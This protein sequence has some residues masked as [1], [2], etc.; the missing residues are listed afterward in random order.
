VP[1]PW[2]HTRT[3]GR[4][5]GAWGRDMTRRGAVD[6]ESSGGEGV[7]AGKKVKR[8]RRVPLPGTTTDSPQAMEGQDLATAPPSLGETTAEGT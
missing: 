2:L 1:A 8:R 6:E 5:Q 3:W 7:G 4:V